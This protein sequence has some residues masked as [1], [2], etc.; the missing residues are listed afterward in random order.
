VSVV[1]KRVSIAP[2]E[3]LAGEQHSE[4]KHEYVAGHL[5]AMVGASEPHN[6]VALNLATALKAHLRGGPCRVFISDM[7]VRVDDI[8]YYPDVFVSCDRADDHLY[9]KTR[10]VLVV[11]VVSPSTEPRDTLEKR[12]AYQSLAS[13][14]EYVLAAQDRIEVKVYRRAA[15]GWDLEVAT[16]GDRVRLASVGLELPVEQ[17]YEDAWRT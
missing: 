7:K 6:Q 17:I 10:P 9:Y 2:E 13:V 12:V 1:Q 5:Y 14:Q 4:V 15:D 16:P 3:Y 11:E 8:F